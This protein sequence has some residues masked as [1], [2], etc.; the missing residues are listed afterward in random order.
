M[1]CSGLKIAM[2]QT[3]LVGRGG[4][5]RQIL[6]L[7]I[8]LQKLGHEVE[9]FT[10]AVNEEKCYPSL[11]KKVVVNIVPFPPDRF[12]FLYQVFR[13]G[14]ALITRVTG[15][16]RVHPGNFDLYTFFYPSMVNLARKI[17]KG[18]DLINNHNFPTEWAAFFAKK[19]L[20]IPVVWMCNEPPFWFFH[21]E[22]TKGFRKISWPLYEVFDRIAVK[23]ID[24]IIV[25]SHITEELIKKIYKRVPK[26]IRSGVDIEFFQGASGQEIRKKYDLENDFVLLQVGRLVYFKRQIDS[27]KA[28]FYLSRRYDNVKLILEGRGPQ[29]PLRDLSKKLGVEDRLIFLSASDDKELA[30]IYAACDVFLFPSKLTW[31]LVVTEAMAAA[32]AVIVSN[33]AGVSEIIENYVNGIV[34]D[35]AK[36][37]EIAGH[38][39]RLMD[40]PKLRKKLGENAYEYVKRNLSWRKYAENMESVFEQTISNFRRNF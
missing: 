18:F 28:L 37:K 20:K 1:G 15:I 31:G 38:V 9:I 16:P 33:K 26:I 3:P 40:D 29:K 8:E 32:R 24:K 27:L 36:P 30:K 34:V 7:A 5:E 10:N 39:K 17:P 35:H 4:G 6:R 25:L 12:R 2:I 19:R 13:G 21:P 11:L 22:Q 14:D 23:Y